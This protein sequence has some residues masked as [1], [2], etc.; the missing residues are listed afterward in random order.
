MDEDLKDRPAVNKHIHPPI[1][2]FFYIVLAVLLGRFIPTPFPHYLRMLGLGLIVAGLLL[3]VGAFHEFR[4]AHT[5]LDPHGSVA[6]LVTEGPY[7]FTRNPIY[8]GF[9]LMVVGFPLNAGSYSGIV[10]APLFM[11][12]LNYL[13]IEKEEAYLE[14]KFGQAYTDYR[15]RVRRWL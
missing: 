10:V 13:V 7:Q 3:G 5:T 14:G 2:A 4:K 8:L 1:V 15:S 11:F 12:T 9:A 6:A